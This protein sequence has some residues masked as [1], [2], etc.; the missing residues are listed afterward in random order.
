ME[1]EADALSENGK[2]YL[3]T[4][5]KSAAR[6]GQMVDD[7]LAFSRLGRQELGVAPVDM[8]A[9]VREAWEEALQPGSNAQLQLKSVPPALGDR[10]MLHEVWANLISNALKYS[11]K[12]PQP[13]VVIEGKSLSGE[14]QYSIRDNGVGFD[15]AHA[16][17]LFRVFERLH[18]S[19]EFEGSGAGL[20][21]VERIVRRHGGRAWAQS[22]VGKGATFYFALPAGGAAPATTSFPE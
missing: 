1:K 13:C 3:Q 16:P 7:L 20:A 6:M 19:Q 4:C 10:S 22:E 8:L 15:M 14:L 21:I 11:A 17:K 5:M 18:G 12:N 9:L 2:R